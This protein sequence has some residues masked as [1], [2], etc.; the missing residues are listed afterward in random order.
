MFRDPRYSIRPGRQELRL[1]QLFVNLSILQYLSL[2]LNLSLSLHPLTGKIVGSR[3]FG[4]S[5][6]WRPQRQR[7]SRFLILAARCG[8]CFTLNDTVVIIIMVTMRD[9]VGSSALQQALATTT[10]A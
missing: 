5:K 1:I 4:F 10:A 8:L 6:L 9:G 7:S 3:D 2:S